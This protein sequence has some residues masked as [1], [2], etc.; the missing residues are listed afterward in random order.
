M[1]NTLEN[2]NVHRLLRKRNFARISYNQANVTDLI[3][4]LDSPSYE[5]LIRFDAVDESTLAY[6]VEMVTSSSTFLNPISRTIEE[7]AIPSRSTMFIEKN[8]YDN[9]W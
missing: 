3:H 8:F 4:Q 1:E 7:D 6:K 5:R 9:I 2:H